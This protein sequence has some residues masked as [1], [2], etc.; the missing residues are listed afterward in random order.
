MFFCGCGISK[1]DHVLV[2]HDLSAVWFCFDS[3]TI[4]FGCL[5][6]LED[7]WFYHTFTICLPC[8]YLPFI[9]HLVRYVYI[10]AYTFIL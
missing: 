8:V 5:L 3:I 2:H 7:N 4:L 6:E 10:I 9:Y 1:I